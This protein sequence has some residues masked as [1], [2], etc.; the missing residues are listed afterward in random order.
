[1]EFIKSLKTN[2]RDILAFLLL[3]VGLAAVGGTVDYVNARYGALNEWSAL[4][5]PS[6]S[7]YFQGFSKFV[8]AVVTASIFYMFTWPAINKFSNAGFATAWRN[9]DSEK[10]LYVYVA[11]MAVALLAASICFSS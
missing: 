10:K 8:G 1:M 3:G 5:L 11:L 7:N 4:M 2:W 6:L 9:L